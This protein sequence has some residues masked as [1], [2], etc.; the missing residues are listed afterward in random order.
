MDILVGNQ[1]GAGDQIYLNNGDGSFTEDTTSTITSSRINLPTSA[2]AL[3]DIDGDGDLDAIVD[4]AQGSSD[5]RIELQFNNRL[6]SFVETTTHPIANLACDFG[7]EV[8]AMAFADLDGDGDMDLLQGSTASCVDRMLRGDGNG[9]FQVDDAFGS[10]VARPNS[11]GWWG[12]GGLVGYSTIAVVAGDVDGDNDIDVM[13]FRKRGVSM[14]INGGNGDFTDQSGGDLTTAHASNLANSGAMGDINGDGSLDVVKVVT[15]PTERSQLLLND[16]AGSFTE[17]FH[18]S[19]AQRHTCVA[20]GDVN[21][22]QLLDVVFGGDKPQG[23]PLVYSSSALYIN[24]GCSG[25]SCSFISGGGGAI[26]SVSY[27]STLT[28]G[29]VD[30]DGGA[31]VGPNLASHLRRNQHKSSARGRSRPLCRRRAGPS[32]HQRWHRQFPNCDRHVSRQLRHYACDRTL[33][34]VDAL[35]LCRR[36]RHRR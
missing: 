9:D 14:Y 10:L 32:P 29:D 31:L 17:G 6:G 28:F 27:V 26:T 1:M 3:A 25:P 36:S 15:M 5:A 21:G 13:Y 8:T 18:F 12:V 2:M 24:D 30:G 4:K 20:L 23:Y 35:D 11:A 19:A 33:V 22:D 16:G 7:D 34:V